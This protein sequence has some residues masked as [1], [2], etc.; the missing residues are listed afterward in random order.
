M[1]LLKKIHWYHLLL[2]GVLCV[3]FLSHFWNMHNFPYFEN[4]EGT[5]M[6]QAWSLVKEGKLAPYTYWYDHAPAGWI[7]IA[8]WSVVTHGFST[9]GLAVDSGRVFML[10]LHVIATFFLFDVARKVT[11]QPWAG[12]VAALIFSLSPLAIYFQRRVLLDNIMIFWVLFSFWLLITE[13]LTLT[14]MYLSAVTFGIAVLTKE[15][16]IFFCPAFLYAVYTFSHQKH[17]SFAVVLWTVISLSC[18]SLYFLY[19]VLNHEFWPV[20]ASAVQE[21]VSLVTSL[22][23]QLSRGKKLPFFNPGSDFYFSFVQWMQKDMMLILVGITTGLTTLLLSIKFKYFRFPALLSLFFFLFY[24]R[25]GLVIDF[26]IIPIIPIFALNVG[27][28]VDYAAYKLSGGSYRAYSG[29]MILV[30][31]SIVFWY[32]THG[33]SQYTVNE[34]KVQ[35]E[36]FTW[37]NQNVPKD[38]V[39]A[40]DGYGLVD[41]W[42]AGYKKAIWF[43]KLWSDPAVGRKLMNSWE[44]IDYVFLSHEMVRTMEASASGSKI[45][46]DAVANGKQQRAFGPIDATYID[47]SKY[48][49]TNGDWVW[50]MK[51]ES[52]SAGIL[53]NS[54]KTY[55]SVFMNKEGQVNDDE[56]KQTTS[57][58]QSYA[59]LRA[60]YMNDQKTFDNVLLWTN[61]HL[62][63]R[64]DALFAWLYKD[65]VVKDTEAATDADLDTALSLVFASRVWK[66]PQYLTQAKQ[67]LKDIWEREVV[68][69]NGRYVLIAYTHAKQSDGSYMVNPSYFS[70]AHY[71][72]FQGVDPDHEW[73]KLA[74]DTYLTLAD[75]KN[76]Q[77]YG[78]SQQLPPN[79][80]QVSSDGKILSAQGIMGEQASQFGFDA[81][82]T[83]F[84]VALDASW[85]NTQE[86]RIYL[87]PIGKLFAGTWENKHAFVGMYSANGTGIVSYP[88]ISTLGGIAASLWVSNPEYAQAVLHDIYYKSYVSRNGMWLEPAHYFDQNWAWFATAFLTNNFPN[89]MK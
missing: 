59:L 15:N 9:F 88:S 17:R 60:V 53:A 52:P 8:L 55:T 81:F 38:A 44:S 82:R 73:G 79:W 77:V 16:A 42:Q 68:S 89:L 22:L 10:V 26:Y 28:L 84:R 72:V 67:L 45:L 41:Y 57:E 13:K 74:N 25:G 18:V 58:G 19:A 56:K 66:N 35:R 30:C 49:S 43:W 3:A 12:V 75:I 11:K 86:A 36:A 65:G 29:V 33:M 24:I 34:T 61:E 39:I 64:G 85:F 76:A 14:R 47:L 20:P 6:S 31:I 54:W 71:R 78:K 83:L 32:A 87:T 51:V 7:F 69:V 46:K 21:R 62:K 2:I 27:M 1:K 5:Y 37:M 50:P 70:P 48:L 63:V 23:D 40:V 80:V 4:D